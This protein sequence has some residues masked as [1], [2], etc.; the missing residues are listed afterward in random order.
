[1]GKGD[2][3]P[4]HPVEDGGHVR[5]GY[6]STMLREL[7]AD[8]RLDVEEISSCSG[9]VSQWLTRLGHFGRIGHFLGLPFRLFPAPL[10]RPLGWLLGVPDYSICMVATKPRFAG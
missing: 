8:C 3:G 4:F 1:M 7:C 5:R 2:I 6:N 10:N 9:P